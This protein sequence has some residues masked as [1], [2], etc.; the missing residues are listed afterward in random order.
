MEG[1][2]SGSPT[3]PRIFWVGVAV[4]VGT[5]VLGLRSL[6]QPG[7][8]RRVRLVWLVVTALLASGVIGAWVFPALADQ[9]GGVCSFGALDYAFASGVQGSAPESC[10]EAS[11]IQVGVSLLLW[12]VL[13][14]R[15]FRRGDRHGRDLVRDR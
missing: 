8:T 6:W 2:S 11:R 9:H 12:L 15:L 3:A 14:V 13:L 5:A 1:W 10:R 7:A 4:L